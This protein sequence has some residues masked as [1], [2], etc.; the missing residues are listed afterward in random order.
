MGFCV[1]CNLLKLMDSL[2]FNRRSLAA[3]LPEPASGTTPPPGQLRWPGLRLCHH[4]LLTS[5][6]SVWKCPAHGLSGGPT[7]S[8]DRHVQSCDAHPCLRQ[9]SI[10]SPVHRADGQVCR[11]HFP[12]ILG[13]KPDI[14]LQ[15]FSPAAHSR[16]RQ[17]AVLPASALHS[18]GLHSQL[19]H[20]TQH[21]GGCSTEPIAGLG[22]TGLQQAELQSGAVT[23]TLNTLCWPVAGMQFKH[24]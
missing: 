22:S 1:L 11:L 18:A 21:C 15:P 13:V 8:L 6:G 10:G 24:V 2:C 19:F 23:A 3:Y 4:V 14:G 16:A 9:H 17:S 5:E 20:R 7:A 12:H